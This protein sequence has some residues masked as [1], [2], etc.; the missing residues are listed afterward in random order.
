VSLPSQRTAQLGVVLAVAA[1]VRGAAA[2]VRPPW[3]DEYFTAWAAALPLGDLL[4]ALH[5]DSGP[6]L[7]YLL[8]KMLVSV[9]LPGLYAAR[10][11]AL[12]AGLLAVWLGFRAAERCSG[13]GAALACGALLATH[14]LAV[15]WSSE[16]RAYALVLFAAAWSWERIE[17]IRTTGRG[18][19]GL[20][21]ALAV[22]VWSHGL[23]PA[24][25]GAVSI[26]SLTLPRAARL[27]CLGAA[28]IGLAS[29]LPWLPVAVQQPSAAT[30]WMTE[31]WHGTRLAERLLSPVRLLA[32]LSPFGSTLD[33]PS[34]PLALQ[35]VAAAACVSLLFFGRRAHVA[36]LIAA[37]PAFGLPL[38]AEMGLPAFYPGRAEAF[39]LIPVL[40]VMGIG[41]VRSRFTGILAATLALGGAA[42]VVAGCVRWVS[43]GPLPEAVVAE[44]IRQSLPAGGMVVTSGY[45]GLDVASQLRDR[46][47]LE[48]VSVPPGAARHPGWFADGSDPFG[49]EDL[50]RLTRRALGRAGDT[51]VIVSPSLTSE[52]PLRRLAARL[53]LVPVV[54]VPGGVLFLS[55][56][57]GGGSP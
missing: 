20:A 11:L 10:A 41:A 38:L 50:D 37:V 14:P 40:G 49:E 17:A 52:R 21:A 4:A 34:P 44:A 5:L 22:A 36:V 53:G 57:T 31:A 30:A 2:L 29:L 43:A 12:T 46:K 45:W 33:M 35:L 19:A 15:A 47:Q 27:R 16:G 9:G 32:P 39:Y 26:A 55:R 18:S 6:P 3:H 48:F 7:P 42:N 28:A 1:A 8:T 54:T 23:G 13:T 51:A 25:V 56:P 24:L